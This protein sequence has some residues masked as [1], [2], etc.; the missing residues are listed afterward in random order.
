MSK[1]KKIY[2]SFFINYKFFKLFLIF[3][4]KFRGNLKVLGNKHI[5]N[6]FRKEGIKNKIIVK[7]RL[8]WFGSFSRRQENDVQMLT[9]FVIINMFVRLINKL[10]KYNKNKKRKNVMVK[11][12]SEIKEKLIVS[13]SRCRENDLHNINTF[14]IW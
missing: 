6:I 10:Q 2:L 9:W 14:I 3:F 11:N 1:T 5:E 8:N 13:F 4:Q 7:P 12:A